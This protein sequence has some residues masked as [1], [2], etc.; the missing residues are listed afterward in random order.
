MIYHI[1]RFAIKKEAPEGQL[2]FRARP[3]A[4]FSL[5][6]PAGPHAAPAP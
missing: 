3:R 1:N 5:N 2:E 4:H 6:L